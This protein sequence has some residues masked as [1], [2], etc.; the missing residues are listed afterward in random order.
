MFFLKEKFITKIDN[1]F[2]AKL[3]SVVTNMSIYLYM[4]TF[5]R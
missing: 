3:K 4:I 1:N 2:E 5:I